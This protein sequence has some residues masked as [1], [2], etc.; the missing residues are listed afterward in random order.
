MENES[1]EDRAIRQLF[2]DTFPV[3]VSLGD[4][5]WFRAYSEGLFIINNHCIRLK[6]EDVVR[7]DSDGVPYID[8]TL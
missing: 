1:E 2:Y 3:K 4:Q 7:L 5:E 6:P 8:K